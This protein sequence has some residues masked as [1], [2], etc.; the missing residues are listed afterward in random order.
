MTGLIDIK[1]NVNSLKEF[2]RLNN[3]AIEEEEEAKK[4]DWAWR[5]EK[6][7]S[8]AKPWTQEAKNFLGNVTAIMIMRYDE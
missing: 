5:L 3:E 2:A 6:D 7:I 1:H 8:I 4:I